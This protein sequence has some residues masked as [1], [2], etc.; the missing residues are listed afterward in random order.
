M[1]RTY[2]AFISPSPTFCEE[3]LRELERAD[4]LQTLRRT[5]NHLSG[6]VEFKKFANLAIAETV[7]V[8]FRGVQYFSGLFV[9]E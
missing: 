5:R 8:S 9:F 7:N 3:S 4:D 1:H 6:V 2:A